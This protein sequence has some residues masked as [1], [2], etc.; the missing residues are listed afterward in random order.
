MAL[1]SKPFYK[2]WSFW[3]LFTVFLMV[4]WFIGYGHILVPI[5]PFT[6]FNTRL[7]YGGLFFAFILILNLS[8]L[9][10]TKEENRRRREERRREFIQKNKEHLLQRK[11]EKAVVLNLRK[12][13]YNAK[14][15]I[16]NASI[17][18]MRPY[19]NYELPWYL[20]IGEEASKKASVL[21]HSGLDFPVNINYAD[22]DYQ[23]NQDD[24]TS[25]RWFFAEESI[26]V[27]VPSPYVSTDTD[28]LETSVWNEFLRLFKKERWQR[29]VNG[30]ILTLRTERFSKNTQEQLEEYAKVLRSRFDELSQ[31]FVSDIPI[32]VIVSGIENLRGFR[33]F[34]HTLTN[35]EK[36]EILGIT[37]EEKL[38][39][40]N[41][42][43]I[44]INFSKL[45]QK[46]ESDRIDKLHQEWNVKSRVDAYFF[47]D[48]FREL[49]T[50]LTH[51]TSKV[52]SKTRYHAPLMLRGIYFTSIDNHNEGSDIP[53]GIFLPKVFERIILSESNLVKIDEKFKKKYALIQRALMG[54]LL[55][56]VIGSTSYWSWF[57]S[58]ENQ[59]IQKVE[60]TITT[61][62]R[63]QTEALPS[64]ILRR[65]GSKQLPK[66]EFKQIGKLGGI[67]GNGNVNFLSNSAELT[68]Y[69][70]KE[71]S[72]IADKIKTFDS[73]T[74]IQILGYT[75]N[76]GDE[77]RNVQLSLDRA[78]AVKDYFV[79][80]GINE[81]RLVSMGKGSSNPVQ[82]NETP[83]GQ[84]LNR[85]VEIFA[86]GIQEE[87]TDKS[88]YKESYSIKLR[89]QE[90]KE[91]LHT[92]ET[93]C[94]IGAN[95]ERSIGHEFWKPGFYKVD[96]RMD[97]L[98]KLYYQTLNTL[99]LDRVALLIERELLNNLEDRAKTIESLTAYL[100]LNNKERR[101]EDPDF[102]KQYM[103]NR[104]GN[105]DRDS[106][107]K[108][109]KHF[110]TLLSIEMKSAKLNE[111]SIKRARRALLSKDGE[112]GLYYKTLIDETSR[113]DGVNAFEFNQALTSSPEVIRGGEYQIKGIYTK[114]GY[115]KVISKSSKK[116]LEDAI[117]KNWILGKTNIYQENKDEFKNLHKRV[118][119]LYFKDYREKWMY[120]LGAIEIPKYSD[121]KDLTKQLSLYSSEASPIIDILIALK[122][123]TLILTNEEEANRAMAQ[124]KTG[125]A[126]KTGKYINSVK[127]IDP[128][129]E[130]KL[131]LRKAFEDFHKLIDNGGA[132]R[133]LIPF[134]K[135][136]K[137]VY[138]LM[139]MVESSTEKKETAYN[140]ITNNLSAED[141]KKNLAGFSIK[142]SF[143]P[144][145]VSNKWYNTML[146]QN[147]KG[148]T[149]I[150]KDHVQQEFVEEIWDDYASKIANKF[151]LNLESKEDIK[152]DNF[153]AFFGK[154]GI[155]DNFYKKYLLEY[156]EVD[157]E[158]KTY[159]KKPNVQSSIDDNLVQSMFNMY[160]IQK[161][162]F[163]EEGSKL[164]IN[165]QIKPEKLTDTL[166]TM[167]VQYESQ[168]LMY[169]HGPKLGVEF[170]LPGENIESIAK[171]TLYDFHLKRVVKV[172]GH[173]EWALLRLLYQLNP[174]VIG[175]E[176]LETKIGLSYQ[177]NKRNGSLILS[178]K[179]S[180]IFSHNN[181]LTSFKLSK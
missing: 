142:H 114:N 148:L 98:T 75:D 162:V 21:R 62:H 121:I 163:D 87:I 45:L 49:L 94:D 68:E 78:N 18:K 70:K 179:S 57:V 5:E 36:K 140:I 85:R 165:F 81:R 113:M 178:G 164:D 11:E 46:L 64:L 39:N 86:Y 38:L 168:L 30:I 171:F 3:L 92:L 172:R 65:E 1:N 170:S 6:E 102:L 16:G 35:E 26:F 20:V 134:Q 23:D 91:V 77:E 161:L 29:P 143:I 146:L 95:K 42:D 120:A 106:I 34:F 174:K 97:W 13:F 24:M 55:L 17:Y 79:S 10:F 82:S 12:R 63:V 117:E 19:N 56:I 115:K 110:A 54:L 156:I 177:Q 22:S 145:I 150:S 181:P 25:F 31:A 153:V 175:G 4:A 74:H 136:L 159:T 100:L 132:S 169:E 14:K 37:F 60:H 133:S 28:R 160:E 166:S 53:K 127:G 99:L 96:E 41:A 129:K 33:E 32:Y 27:N 131:R 123:N 73:T 119:D 48:E 152:V 173:G 155:L 58:Q 158:T 43:T 89:P 176:G 112:V 90:W 118:L 157:Y 83:E 93:L 2:S 180:S 103:L 7:L 151:P 51:F 139:I 104:W 111:K 15:T 61:Y 8:Y 154:G 144:P 124:D 69:G 122:K 76:V 167:E 44:T 59:E 9:L 137:E 72:H 52:F 109:N 130:Y 80:L 135:R 128:H 50:K 66:S 47:N 101:L 71:L 105:L 149:D 40:I 88:T 125:I 116:V 107:Q 147:W 84:S 138:Q 108:L 67:H 141:K 126:A